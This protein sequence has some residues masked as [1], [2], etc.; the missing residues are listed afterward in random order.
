MT[1]LLFAATAWA[2]EP[3]LPRTCLCSPPQT[4]LARAV[5]NGDALQIKLKLVKT[6]AETHTKPVTVKKIKEVDGKQVEYTEQQ[7][8]K[9]CVMKPVGW[10]EVTLQ[11]DT[12]GVGVYDVQG[13]PVAWDK[14]AKVLTKDTPVLVS[15]EPVDPFYLQTM[16]PETLVIVG[17]P[18]AI[19]GAPMPQIMTTPPGGNPAATN[20][21]AASYGAIA[22]AWSK[23]LC[24]I[25]DWSVNAYNPRFSAGQ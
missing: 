3:A 8:A 14:V 22:E 7:L 15:T 4:A 20:R 21:S 23:G 25:A 24:F 19:Y 12:L 18:N 10:N 11:T 16:K 6:V 1:A 17:P 13:K 2:D 5:K 9:V